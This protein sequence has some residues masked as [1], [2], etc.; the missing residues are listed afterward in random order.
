M[1]GILLVLLAL[2]L[3]GSAMWLNLQKTISER[4]RS[5]RYLAITGNTAEQEQ[6]REQSLR[7]RSV[8]LRE[9]L[10][11]LRNLEGS[12]LVESLSV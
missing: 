6:M 7:Q 12:A 5:L 10:I 2:V 1:V 3:L 8:L 11:A 4:E 9:S